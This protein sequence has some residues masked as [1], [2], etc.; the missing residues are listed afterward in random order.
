MNISKIQEQIVKILEENNCE[1]EAV[2]EL[3]VTQLRELLYNSIIKR[4]T[5][6]QLTG[7]YPLI[8]KQ[9]PHNN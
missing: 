7:N 8:I 5:S 3:S 2:I 6:V 9:K 1:I 4:M